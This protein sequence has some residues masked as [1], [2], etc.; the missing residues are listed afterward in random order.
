MISL[1]M[2]ESILLKKYKNE[3]EIA[4]ALE[5]VEV[6]NKPYITCFSITDVTTKELNSYLKSSGVSNI[7]KINNV[8]KL[9]SIPALGTGKTDY[10]SL[11]DYLNA[12]I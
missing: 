9:K 11:K 4:L 3:E 5:Y 12:Q 8:I 6:N 7:V 1:P 2:I 10:K